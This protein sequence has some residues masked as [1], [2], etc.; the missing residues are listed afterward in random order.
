M[1]IKCL[2]KPESIACR[3]LHCRP[4]NGAGDI[5][6]FAGAARA[7]EAKPRPLRRDRE[8]ALFLSPAR[9]FAE[10]RQEKMILHKCSLVLCT[11]MGYNKIKLLP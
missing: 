5:L 2:R 1:A 7:G 6:R 3:G 4:A 10:L 9:P 8:M 11:K